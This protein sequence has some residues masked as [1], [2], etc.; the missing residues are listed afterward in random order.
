MEQAH[1]IIQI[2]NI[3]LKIM[4]NIT[5]VIIKKTIVKLI[6]KD[7]DMS[8]LAVHINRMIGELKR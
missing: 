2:K 4:E 3:V 5:Y 6:Y 1:K 7:K 8:E